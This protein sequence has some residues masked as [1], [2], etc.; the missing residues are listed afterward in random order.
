MTASDEGPTTEAPP[1]EQD[2][3]GDAGA[4]DVRT[5]PVHAASVKEWPEPT[6]RT[7]SAR[8]VARLA[9]SIRSARSLGLSMRAGKQRCSPVQLRD[10]VTDA[11]QIHRD[12]AGFR[13]W[14]RW[15]QSTRSNGKVSG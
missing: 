15:P 9:A 10:S 3:K 5:S 12:V 7:V 6:A 1:A 11:A 4:I 14:E 8:S 2:A 13:G